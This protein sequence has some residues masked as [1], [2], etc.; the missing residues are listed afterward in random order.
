M[1]VKAREPMKTAQEVIA[2]AEETKAANGELFT[3]LKK[4]EQLI[5]AKFILA[6]RDHIKELRNGQGQQAQA[7]EPQ[8][9]A[10]ATKPEAK[11]DELTEAGAK[12]PVEVLVLKSTNMDYFRAN[13][14]SMQRAYEL[15]CVWRNCDPQNRTIFDDERKA[16]VKAASFAFWLN[17]PHE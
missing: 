12:A 13:N 8:P 2:W 7:A 5:I 6:M 11:H 15:Y 10:E 1:A 9:E 4:E 17:L 16:W 14:I 3:M